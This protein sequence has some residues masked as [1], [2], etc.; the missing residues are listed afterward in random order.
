MNLTPKS[1]NMQSEITVETAQVGDVI[2]YT[3]V[4]NCNKYKITEV[5]DTDIVYQS[6]DGEWI[7]CISFEQ[8]SKRW[9]FS[10]DCRR[11]KELLNV[12]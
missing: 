2:F 3:D 1:W 6:E 7:D 11:I 9:T 5:T 10:E 4:C 12:I 8:L